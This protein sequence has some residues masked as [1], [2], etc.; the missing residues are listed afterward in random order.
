ME[1]WGSRRILCLTTSRQE[2][3]AILYLA[4]LLGL[5]A[6]VEGDGGGSGDHVQ[7]FKAAED[8]HCRCWLLAAGCRPLGRHLRQRGLARSHLPHLPWGGAYEHRARSGFSD[9]TTGSARY[10]CLKP[11][12]ADCIP[13]TFL[14]GCAVQC[15]RDKLFGGHALSLLFAAPTILY[16]LRR[17]CRS[18]CARIP[19]VDDVLQSCPALPYPRPSTCT[20]VTPPLLSVHSLRPEHT[21]DSLFQAHL[22]SAARD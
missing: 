22:Q 11:T 7:D 4:G 21:V 5:R 8:V 9:C 1:L 18:L 6:L 10:C 3:G 15:S 17:H 2:R 16:S 13:Q 14:T 20:R 19:N 12:Y